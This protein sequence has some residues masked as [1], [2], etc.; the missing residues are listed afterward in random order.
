MNYENGL[1]YLLWVLVEGTIKT[2]RRIDVFG[3][4]ISEL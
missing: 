3:I 4:F 2:V 1:L